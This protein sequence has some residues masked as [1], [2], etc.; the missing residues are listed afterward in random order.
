M[1]R[2]LLGA[3]IFLACGPSEVDRTAT[4]VP[5]LQYEEVEEFVELPE[6]V[7]LGQV[8]G[9]AVDSLDRL[10]VFHRAGRAFDNEDPIPEPTILVFDT[11][12]GRLLDE[13]GENLFVV[14]HGLAVDADGHV[15]ATDARSNEVLELSS[16]GQVLSRWL[17]NE[18]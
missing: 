15:W 4:T 12:S 3:S 5:A 17:G 11:V 14:P 9:L 13:F 18:Q 2:G 10:Y 7:E 1:K 16:D 6:G 8:T